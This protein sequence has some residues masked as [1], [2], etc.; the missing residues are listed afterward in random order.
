MTIPATAPTTA[1]R[2][3]PSMKRRRLGQ[4]SGLAL[5]VLTSV[6]GCS[7]F[8]SNIK[9]GFACSAPDGSCAPTTI[10]D[11]GALRAIKQSEKPDGSG[12][13]DVALPS[14]ASTP[15][16]VQ[17]ATVILA[18]DRLGKDGRG[19][20]AGPNGH[21]L[22]V[23]YPAHRDGS[24]RMVPKTIAYALVD[25]PEWAE[26]QTGPV[27]SVDGKVS[28]GVSRGLLGAAEH[29]P[30]ALAMLPASTRMAS[31]EPQQAAAPPTSTPPAPPAHA[32]TALPQD[33]AASSPIDQIKAQAA[34]ILS[35]GKVK[36]AGTFSPSGN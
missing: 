15:S 27:M 22:R 23:V 14:G 6:A 5:L 33:G 1:G 32:P 18:A 17:P 25:L 20:A 30:D 24:G 35:A 8:H 21:A 34:Q 36:S 12:A 28:T 2:I 10:I 13:G 26:R 3:D 7:M 4:L 16:P 31:A 9:G 29:A 11:D 19:A